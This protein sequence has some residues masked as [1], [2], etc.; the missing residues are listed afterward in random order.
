V[1]RASEIG[2]GQTGIR[3]E[4]HETKPSDSGSTQPDDEPN[5]DEDG[6]RRERTEVDSDE[7]DVA[8]TLIT[9]LR[10]DDRREAVYKLL[11]EIADRIDEQRT[12]YFQVTMT[13][14]V[15]S[16]IAEPIAG[17]IRAAG[18]TANVRDT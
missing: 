18:A 8:F 3:L 12:S 11:M 13:L 7:K 10:D 2:L 14:R 15:D 5:G 16:S 17:S 6:A 1:Q 9:G 4:V